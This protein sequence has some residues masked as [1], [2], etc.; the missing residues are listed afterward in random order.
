MRQCRK[1]LAILLIVCMMVSILPSAAFAQNQSKTADTVVYNLLEEEITVGNDAAQAAETPW[2]YKLFEPDGSYTIQLE[3]NAFFPY[4]VQFI[5]DGVADTVW[6]ATPESTVEIGGHLFSVH[7]EQNDATQLSQLGFYVGSD[8]VPAYPE[9]KEFSTTSSGISFYSLLPLQEKRV[10]V[11]LTG[12]TPAELK[13]VKVSTILSGIAGGSFT[14]DED[15]VWAKRNNVN[16]EFHIISQNET[17]DLISDHQMTNLQLI[18]GTANQLDADNIRYLVSIKISDR[19]EWL[20]PELYQQASDGSRTALEIYNTNYQYL[21]GSLVNKLNIGA[22]P[23]FDYQDE[24]YVSLSLNEA[25]QNRALDVSVYKGV[26]NTA[27][28]AA[29]AVQ[30]DASVDITSQIW[31]QTM[32]TKDAGYKGIFSNYDAPQ[33]VTIVLKEDNKV[34]GIDSFNIWVYPS[35]NTVY[36]SGLY[37]QDN[38]RMISVSGSSRSEII[39]NTDRTVTYTL[40]AGYA[41]DAD[42]YVTLIYQ[43]K[44]TNEFESTNIQKAV[45]GRYDTLTA[46]ANRPDIKESLFAGDY[47]DTGNPGYQANYSGNGVTFTIFTTNN[48]TYKL[49]VK[50]VAQEV[51]PG[52]DLGEL[53]SGDPYFQ[54]AG[55]TGLTRYSDIYQ[56]DGSDD[57]YYANG[58]QTLL[59]VKSDAD[60]KNLKLTFDKAAK[61]TIYANG[62]EQISG[63]TTQDFSNGP[64]QYS[65]SAEDGTHLKNY[66]VTVVKQTSGAKLFI[67]GANVENENNEVVREVFLN[68]IYGNHHDIFIANIGDVAL[69]GLKAELSSAQNVKLDDYWTVGGE[70]N[71]TLAAFTTVYS[72]A[73]YGELAN[74][75]KVR[76]IPDGDGIVSGTLTISADGQ[77]P[78]VIKLTGVA[79]NPKIV[80]AEL[81]DAVKYVP[82]GSLIQQNN[83]YDWN[84]VSFK[85][86][87]GALPDGM[88]IKRNG[89]LYGVPTQTGT[90]EFTVRMDNSDE[91][92]SSSEATFTLN[93]LENTDENV[94]GSTDTGYDVSIRVPDFMTSYQDEVFESQGKLSDFID[95]W[96]DG[97]KL[98][99]GTDYIA[100]EGST[101]ITVRSQT[102]QKAGP[103]K[104]T[105]AAEFRVGG[106]VDKELKRAAQNYELKLSGGSSGGSGSSSGGGSGS[107]SGGGVKPPVQPTAPVVT[108]QE[109]QIDIFA[110]VPKDAWYAGEAAWVYENGLMVGVGNHQFAPDAEISHATVV[111]VLARLGKI[112]LTPYAALQYGDIANDQWYSAS[113]KWARAENLL[114]RQFSPNPPTPRGELAVILVKYLE[115]M[116]VTLPAITEP[117]IFADVTQMT[118][119]EQQAFQILYKLGVFKGKDKN[120]TMDTQGSTTRAELAALLH[121]IDTIF[122]EK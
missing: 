23:V 64:V 97:E 28:E 51:K 79:G 93:V 120:L 85:L 100:E 41:A 96:M 3:E 35:R 6:F 108:P 83:M 46:A 37:R 59:V 1:G 19:Y 42:Y 50:V 18:V 11:D 57:D 8:Y 84:M 98:T 17:I 118:E 112:D 115:K 110:D 87:D 104:H 102:F 43:N 7:T 66:W 16:D 47:V 95:F 25:Y 72:S 86:A 67:N 15:V 103:G 109:N 10:T 48:E 114:A 39:S 122:K 76:L 31:N 78:V 55:A 82:Y 36:A 4:E 2:A 88:S 69:T 91:R 111:A 63:E 32:E 65:A 26:Y 117:V 90:F 74:V 54:A 116:G 14:G 101:K 22:A 29:S 119:E 70:G 58:Y 13:Q 33:A 73:S 38:N 71:D 49:T 81:P 40:N 5:C 9:P 20:V 27:E 52:S 80:T 75:A 89:E 99:R 62:T 53:P 61:A 106:D 121:R 24:L 60:L 21:N 34:K 44:G 45:L 68:D 56:M 94:D 107:S 77:D 30:K 113:A 12:Y 92:F 105:I